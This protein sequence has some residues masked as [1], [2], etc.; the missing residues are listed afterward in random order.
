MGVWYVGI[1]V[2]VFTL[3]GCIGQELSSVQS[4][5]A[6]VDPEIPS[7][8]GTQRTDAQIQAQRSIVQSDMLAKIASV[9]LWTDDPLHPLV[10][11]IQ[12]RIPL[13]IQTL[14]DTSIY[15]KDS[16]DA[17]EG[18]LLLVYSKSGHVLPIMQGNVVYI[19]DSSWT[20]AQITS[21][22]RHGGGFI[23]L[24]KSLARFVDP[25]HASIAWQS[26][27]ILFELCTQFPEIRKN[28]RPI[29]GTLSLEESL[30]QLV[31]LAPVHSEVSA[32]STTH[33]EDPRLQQYDIHANTMDAITRLHVAKYSTVEEEI[34]VLLDDKDPWVRARAT[35]H[36]TQ[37]GKL[38]MMTTDPS[39]LVRVATAH[40]LAE[41]LQQ[42][43][44]QKEALCPI[45]DTISRSPD[46]YV[47][48]KAAYGLGFCPA[49][50]RL[51]EM[52][53]DV[54]IDVQRQAAQSIQLQADKQSLF[55]ELQQAAQSDNSFVRRWALQTLATF[56]PQDEL[57][58][59]F[60]QRYAQ[61][62]TLLEKD[63][64]AMA[65]QPYGVS[66]PSP[67]YRPPAEPRTEKE[68][69][70]LV[71]SRDATTR[72]D[73]CKYLAGRENVNHWLEVLAKDKD[74]EVRKSAV[75]ALGW[76]GDVAVYGFVN[77]VDMDVRVVALD[78]IRIQRIGTGEGLELLLVDK[79][80]EIRLRTVE[81]MVAVFDT[82]SLEQQELLSSLVQDGDERVRAILAT[83]FPDRFTTDDS[84]WVRYVLASHGH[85]IEIGYSDAMTTWTQDKGDKQY[86]LQGIIEEEDAF[87]HVLF[88]WNNLQDRPISHKVLRPP[89][90]RWY[91]HSNRG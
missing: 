31:L 40:R 22:V 71:A 63:I 72:K 26:T 88:S 27:S 21:V 39:S 1:C 17:R 25:T 7:Q 87:L 64:I 19:F 44:A 24:E 65:V 59:F 69:A 4:G 15:S 30:Q 60:R 74:S 67:R 16:K 90:F 2:C 85:P 73:V 56:A 84:M 50:P 76:N 70:D 38:Q 47:R 75:E 46:A 49:V 68:I 58:E 86:W 8:I 35:V 53:L 28:M 9:E 66:L 6:I 3:L 51:G 48:W 34:S 42:P 11:D 82:L 61:T 32:I 80:A 55:I 29:Q 54:D 78:G 81:A 23:Q 33:K 62:D 83:V 45:V 77:D 14:T 79:D 5:S 91:G 10:Q 18:V 13:G 57:L 36:A 20:D 37:I 12:R 43:E 41:L 89:L 52:L